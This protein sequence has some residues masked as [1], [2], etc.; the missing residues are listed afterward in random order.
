MKEYQINVNNS[1]NQIQK[2]IVEEYD[3]YVVL[4][5]YL[6][7]EIDLVEIPAKINNKNVTIVGDCCFFNHPEIIDVY[8]SSAI[9]SIGNAAFAYCKGI[10]KLD[11]PDSIKEIGVSA[12]RD[13]TGLNR[14]VMPKHLKV[15]SAGL[16]AFCHLNCDAEV[17]LPHEL[18]KIDVHAFYSGGFFELKIPDTVKRIAVGA[19]NGG[20]KVITSLPYDKGWYLDWPYGEKIVFSDGQEGIVS[21]ITYVG[22][23]C[24]NS[25]ILEVTIGNKKQNIFYPSCGENVYKFENIHSQQMMQEDIKNYPEVEELYQAWLNG[26]V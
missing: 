23:D 1:K 25:E 16:F 8:F 22:I 14:V 9:Q 6:S 21:N 19:F 13:C 12:F 18:E 17:V 5:Q 20:P 3:N 11:L 15:L 10:S 26:L 7:N 24:T 2:F 4:K